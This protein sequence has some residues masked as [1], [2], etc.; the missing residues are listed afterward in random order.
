M[1]HTMA[2]EKI[3]D[4]SF[5]SLYRPDIFM[6]IL[7]VGILY[8]KFYGSRTSNFQTTKLQKFFFTAGLVFLYV[9]KGSPLNVIGHHYLFS[10]HMVEM[11]VSYLAVPPLMILGMPHGFYRKWFSR[12]NKLMN[13][14][15]FLTKPLIAI[16]LFITLF[17]IYHMPVIFDAVMANGLLA[18]ISH[19]ILLL[20]AFTMWWPVLC[21]IEELNTLSDLQKVGYVFASGVL[22][23]PACALIMFANDL[24][25]ATYAHVPELYSF[26]PPMEDQM[27]G[28]I[29]M[30]ILQEV[31]YG[32]V[33][34]HIFYKWVKRERA[35][36]K[37]DLALIKMSAANNS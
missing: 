11:A 24:L 9:A 10:V 32:F 20:T 13:T 34:G 14:I 19:T 1:G 28:G 15:S 36:D 29:V 17:S 2:H 16:L 30:K 3:S 25:Y 33:L 4:F 7:M 31:V 35:K 22:L 26:L 6:L 5:Y 21:P 12:Q 37:E 18:L 27:T 23:T 8:Y